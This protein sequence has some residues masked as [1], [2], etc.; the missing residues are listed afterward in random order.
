MFLVKETAVKVIEEGDWV[1]AHMAEPQ[2]MSWVTVLVKPGSIHSVCIGQ[3]EGDCTQML[4][5]QK[6]N[7]SWF[8]Q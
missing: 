8:K 7:A 5:P 2:Q 6:M 4:T 1:E 3:L